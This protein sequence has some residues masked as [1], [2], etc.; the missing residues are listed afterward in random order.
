MASSKQ[1]LSSATVWPRDLDV[2]EKG[3]KVKDQKAAGS[4]LTQNEHRNDVSAQNGA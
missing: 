4:L 1:W 2:P 3:E